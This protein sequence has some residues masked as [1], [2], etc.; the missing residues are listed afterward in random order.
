[1]PEISRQKD[2]SRVRIVSTLSLCSQER[3]GVQVHKSML[4]RTGIVTPKLMC[5][6]LSMFGHICHQLKELGWYWDD[7]SQSYAYFKIV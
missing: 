5:N 1:M 3:K 4:S 7:S 6:M 2:K